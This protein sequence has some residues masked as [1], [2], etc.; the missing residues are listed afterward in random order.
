MYTAQSF[1]ETD[2]SFIIIFF[3][4]IDQIGNWV[5]SRLTKV[6]ELYSWYSSGTVYVQFL[7]LKYST[8]YVQ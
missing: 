5:Q 8:V 7:N 6:W 2:R 4:K 3:V 1:I